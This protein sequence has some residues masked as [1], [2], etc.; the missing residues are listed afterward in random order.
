MPY[1]EGP[2]N[3]KICLVGEAPG[4]DEE[5]Q[6][7]PFVGRAGEELTKLLLAAGIHRSSC[8]ITNVVKVRPANNDIRQFLNID[9]KKPIISQIYLDHVVALKKELSKCTANVICALGKTALYTLVGYRE[10]TKRRGSI[11][12]SKP[13]FGSRKVIPTIH[14][15]A[16]L[17]QYIQRWF[18]ANDL[19]RVKEQSEFPE[20]VLPQRDLKLFPTLPEVLLYID[21][22]RKLSSVAVDI[23]TSRNTITHF[24]IAKSPSDAIC[25][26]FDDFSI[27]EEVEIWEHL[28]ELLEDQQVTKVGQNIIFDSVF[29]YQQLGIKIWPVEDTMIAMGKLYPDFPKKLDFITSVYTNEPYYK[30]DGKKWFKTGGVSDENFRAYNAKDSAVCLEAFDKLVTELKMMSTY[31]AYRDR[32]NLLPTLEYI[33]IR[34]IKMDYKRMES[35]SIK[36]GE[37]LERLLDNFYSICNV[38][39]KE[40]PKFHNSPKQLLYYF[41]FSKGIKPYLKKGKPT[42]DDTALR[43]LARKGI[44][45]AEVLSKIRRIQKMKKTYLDMKLDQ[46]KRLRCSMN[47]MGTGRGRLS[48]SKTIFGTGA[49]MQN[50]TPLIK[51]CML[52]DDGCILVELDKAAAENRVVAYV[53]NES[54]MIKCF[55]EGKDLHRMTAGLI[56]NKRPE[57]VS[58]EPGSCKYG[59]GRYSE[60]FWGKKANH[61]LNY[62]LG[63]KQFALLYEISEN[64]ARYIVE[65]YHSAYPAVRKWHKQI[66][67]QLAK[68]RTLVS[69]APFSQPSTFRDRWSTDL[70]KA[71]YSYIPQATVVELVNQWGLIYTYEKWCICND[72]FCEILNQIHDSIVLQYNLKFGYAPIAQSISDIVRSLNQPLSYD[73]RSFYIPTDGNI[74]FNCGKYSEKNPKG[75]REI[76]R[77]VLEDSLLLTGYL[78]ETFK[79]VI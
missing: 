16:A 28:G 44:K 25:I 40:N 41:Y 70:L 76:P 39:R 24:S 14:P 4:Y 8:Y 34:G 36:A 53:A 33:S 19:Q 78:N 17:R 51:T 74:G 11:Y 37:E 13:E 79:G 65:A 61:G 9:R 18:I 50:Q 30:D 66:Q 21:E 54:K 20:V 55:E 23:E 35:E 67:A 15:A 31:S 7:R 56:F 62:D 71:A 46:D 68:N 29:I 59:G 22:C 77:D 52:A 27:L 60:R 57:E 38:N 26:K 72:N 43:R 69:C 63:Y 58:D 48:S 42:V 5:K 12:Q 2:L 49:N 75:M 1:F 64:E 47:P 45:E 73:G 6:Q 3:C 32:V 10:I